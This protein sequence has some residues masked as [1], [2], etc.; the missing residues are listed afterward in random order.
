VKWTTV[1]IFTNQSYQYSSIIVGEGELF[2]F[3][4]SNENIYY[5]F[6]FDGNIGSQ[7]WNY[8]DID[9]KIFF[10][11]VL[12]KSINTMYLVYYTVQKG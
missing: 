11:Q 4:F 2:Y 7:V 3:S 9:D 6:C 1:L 12:N 10:N 8:T 5:H